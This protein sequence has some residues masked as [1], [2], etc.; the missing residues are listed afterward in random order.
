[1]KRVDK[2][3]TQLCCCRPRKCSPFLSSCN[4]LNVSVTDR[5]TTGTKF[6]ESHVRWSATLLEFHGHTHN[7]KLIAGI[8]FL[9]TRTNHNQPNQASKECQGTRTLFSTAEI[10]A[11]PQQVCQ[12]NVMVYQ[13]DLVPP[14]F[15]TYSMQMFP[16]TIQNFSAVTL[17]NHEQGKIPAEECPHKPKRSQMYLLC[18]T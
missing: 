5:N 9:E 11:L 12:H 8:S 13:P 6:L 18:L 4:R 15:W 14:L 16:H 1:M 10:A 17:V 2:I 3:Y 7:N